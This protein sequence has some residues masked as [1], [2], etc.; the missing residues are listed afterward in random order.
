MWFAIYRFRDM[1]IFS[2]NAATRNRAMRAIRGTQIEM[3]VSLQIF[4]N[5][6][7]SLGALFPPVEFH[8]LPSVA[9]DLN[10]T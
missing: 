3:A 6:R 7:L 5:I 10:K 8:A 4:R 1:P 9:D 2:V